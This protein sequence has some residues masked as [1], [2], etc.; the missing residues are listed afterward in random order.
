MSK[1]S[2]L[3]LGVGL[4]A[5]V[6]LWGGASAG[7]EPTGAWRDECHLENYH[8]IVSSRCSLVGWQRHVR[9][10]PLPSRSPCSALPCGVYGI[11]VRKLPLVGTAARFILE[12]FSWRVS[13][14]PSLAGRFYTR[15]EA[16]Q[17]LEILSGLSYT[18]FLPSQIEEIFW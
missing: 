4:R 7:A 10:S 18:S 6:R 8:R 5:I 17:N 12:H 2:P 15:D 16:Q 3:Q 14:L 13:K 1:Y 9:Y 11:P